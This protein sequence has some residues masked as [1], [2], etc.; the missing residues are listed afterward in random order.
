[1]RCRKV[2]A[3][4]PKGEWFQ[5][6][7]IPPQKI[8]ISFQKVKKRIMHRSMPIVLLALHAYAQGEAS[9]YPHKSAAYTN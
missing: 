5:N 9:L 4:H 8:L 2:A 3:H 1:M 6:N 7:N